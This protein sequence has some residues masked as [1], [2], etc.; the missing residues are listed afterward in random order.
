MPGEREIN[1]AGR[2]LETLGFIPVALSLHSS[3]VD[4]TRVSTAAPA[5][6][7]REVIEKT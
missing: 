6:H 7:A 4:W 1:R 5:N 3:N 2:K